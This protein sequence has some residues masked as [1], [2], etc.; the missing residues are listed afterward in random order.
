MLQDKNE[1]ALEALCKIVTDRVWMN[2]HCLPHALAV[3]EVRN[4]AGYGARWLSDGSEFRGFLEPQMEGGHEL[5][6]RH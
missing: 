3:V 4:S 2:T 5:G 1:R 6:W